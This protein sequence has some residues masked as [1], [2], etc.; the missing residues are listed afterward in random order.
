MSTTSTAAVLRKA[1]PADFD[2]VATLWHDGVHAAH[3]GI[4]PEA[5]MATRTLASLRERL[6]ALLDATVV[7]GPLGAPIGFCAI[8]RDELYQLYVDPVAHGTGVAAQL[9]TDAEV[10]LRESGVSTA[11]LSCAIGNDRAARFYEKSGW[12]RVSTIPYEA[13]TSEGTFPL[14]TWRF[15][16]RLRAG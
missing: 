1:E 12:T 10:R 2:R 7:A 5:L 9:L 13:D 16:K 6:A 3:A 14:L 4:L 11:W 15:E 8:R